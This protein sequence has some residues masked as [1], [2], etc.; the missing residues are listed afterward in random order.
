[1]FDV[2]IFKL[3]DLV[4]VICLTISIVIP[5]SLIVGVVCVLRNWTDTYAGKVCQVLEHRNFPCKL[6]TAILANLFNP[7]LFRRP[8]LS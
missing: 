2:H 5:M 7:G 6:S 4:T 8:F 1:M 3:P